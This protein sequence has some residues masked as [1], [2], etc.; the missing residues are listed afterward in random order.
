MYKCIKCN[1]EFINQ[2]SYNNH[3][4]NNI[5]QNNNTC[6]KCNKNFKVKKY[7]D[8]HI[9]K[10][11][12]QKKE[13]TIYSCKLCDELFSSKKRLTEHQ[14]QHIK[15]NECKCNKCNK[16]FKKFYAFEN[17]VENCNGIFEKIYKCKHCGEIFENKYKLGAHVNAKHS[18]NKGLKD[19][20]CPICK[21]KL[22]CNNGAYKMHINMHDDNLKKEWSNKSKDKMNKFYNSNCKRS[23][24]IRNKSSERMKLN[25]PSKNPE[26][27][28]KMKQSHRK[29]WDNLSD[30]KYSKLVNN[31]INAPKRG[32][33][34]KHNGKYN[35]TSIEKV[36]LDFNI[37]D[38][39]YNGNKKGCK[40]IRFKNKTYRR[41]FTPDFIYKDNICYVETFGV[42]WH[43]KEDEKKYYE[44]FKKNDIKFIIIWEDK[45][46]KNPLKEKKR[47]LKFLYKINNF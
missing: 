38:L 18:N 11:S 10:C 13:L 35:M 17:H 31:Y 6:N 3:V 20:Q 40:I 21:K 8:N 5:C 2:R 28:K 34:V 4:K 45:L 9:S 47:I 7:Y 16:E 25:N 19:F 42:Y 29:Y 44:E 26:V 15:N 23:I 14:T 27:I 1:K 39:K 41:S 32:N 22:Y 30:E 24:E 36:V 43:P 46:L 33:S 12:Y 37:K